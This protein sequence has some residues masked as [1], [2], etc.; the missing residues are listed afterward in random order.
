MRTGQRGLTLIELLIAVGIL[1]VLALLASTLLGTSL[2]NQAHLRSSSRSLEELGL[3]ITLLRR[4][5][6]Q[7]LNRDGRDEYGTRQ[8]SPL[9]SF[10]EGELYQLEFTRD[11][12]RQL[13]GEGFGSSLERIRYGLEDKQFVRYSATVPDPVNATEWRKQKMMDGITGIKFSFYSQGK[14]H[15]EW[16]PSS[17]GLAPSGEGLPLAVSLRLDTER[18]G[19][20]DIMAQIAGGDS[21]S[22]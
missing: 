6:E 17:V 7:M 21:E 8:S 14:W 3:S 18:W 9:L 13:P 12:R 16:P 1:A 4:D 2:D 10:A 5:M 19:V 11:G 22:P 15:R 20:V